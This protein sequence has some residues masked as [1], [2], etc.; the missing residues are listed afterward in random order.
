MRDRETGVFGSSLRLLLL[1]NNVTLAWFGIAVVSI[2]LRISLW[3]FI[4]IRM[5]FMLREYRVI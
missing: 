3:V 2:V 1:P 5:K 4:C